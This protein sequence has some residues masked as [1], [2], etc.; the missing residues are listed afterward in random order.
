MSSSSP[1]RAVTGG[2]WAWFHNLR[3]H[4]DAAVQIGRQRRPVHARVVTPTERARLWPRVI[5]VRRLP[6]LSGAHRAGDPARGPRAERLTEAAYR[7]GRTPVCGEA[8]GPGAGSLGVPPGRLAQL[9]ERRLDKAEVTGSSP[10]SPIPE[11]PTST[12]DSAVSGVAEASVRHQ[13]AGVDEGCRPAR[14]PRTAGA[15][16]ASSPARLPLLHGA[17]A[18][19]VR[20]ASPPGVAHRRAAPAA[21]GLG[22][23][24]AS[25]LLPRAAGRPLGHRT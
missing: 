10:V 16:G 23:R 4:P 13:L 3:A 6:R 7:P 2:T 20:R 1:R 5:E 14:R 12:G 11:S 8:R 19:R 18:S 9:G 22:A 24:G 25:G 17:R 21:E 15:V